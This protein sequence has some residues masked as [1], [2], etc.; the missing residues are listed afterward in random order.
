MRYIKPH[1][2][3]AGEALP[4]EPKM[5]AEMERAE[6]Y[7]VQNMGLKHKIDVVLTTR[8]PGL[9]ISEDKIGGRTYASDFIM[10]D[11]EE[12]K[13]GALAEMLV[14]ELCHAIRWQDN[15]EYI[16]RLLDDIVL[17]GL[18]VAVEAEYAKNLPS[19]TF[20]I[21]TM[22]QRAEAE[23]QKILE[24]LRPELNNARYDNYGIFIEREDL[25]R[26]SGYSLGYYLVQ[27]YLEETDKQI[28]DILAEPYQN[29]AE[30]LKLWD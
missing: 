10:M 28:F 16:Q 6:Q 17:E 13:P 14:H 25:P 15:P 8:M 29:F 1:F 19:R 7:A 26:W 30:V 4:D 27:Q 12:M 2:L 21:E 23:N 22:L 20:F 24:R 9:M 3:N 11:V 18:A 5:L